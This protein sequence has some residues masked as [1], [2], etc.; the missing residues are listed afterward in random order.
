MFFPVTSTQK[1]FRATYKVRKILSKRSILYSTIEF[2]SQ[3]HFYLSRNY[4]PTWRRN[5]PTRTSDFGWQFRSSR[6][7]RGVKLR[8][9]RKSRR[10]TSK[11]RMQIPTVSFAR[12]GI[13]LSIGIHKIWDYARIGNRWGFK[14]ISIFQGVFVQG[15]QGRDQYR[16]KN[17]GGN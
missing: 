6:E 9:R 10:F 14:E 1:Y 16:W 4:S 2:S 13:T 3:L 15:S 5:T 7:V 17:Y 12:L 11:R 8:S